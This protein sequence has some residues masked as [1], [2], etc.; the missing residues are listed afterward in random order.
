[1]TWLAPFAF[2]GLAAIAV[3]ILVHLFG[4]PRARLVRFPTLRFIELTRDAPRRRAVPTDWLLLAVRVAVIGIA[5]AALAKPTWPG[6]GAP[7]AERGLVRV[8]LVD[9]SASLQRLTATGDSGVIVA[10]TEAQRLASESG[11]VL[12]VETAWP[13]L[14]MAGASAWL[15]DRS[16][17]RE[18]VI[19]S[20]F[21]PG[22]I[23]PDDSLR[24]ETGIGIRLVGVGPMATDSSDGGARAI[25]I[26]ESIRSEWTVA[27]VPGPSDVSITA[28]EAD[29]AAATA[30]MHAVQGR[31]ATPGRRVRI[32]LP[33]A[34]EHAATVT[35]LRAPSQPWQGDFLVRLARDA[36]V[37][38][39]AS[40]A[41]GNAAVP[42]GAVPL[43]TDPASAAAFG[44]TLDDSTMVILPADGADPVTWAILAEAAGRAL[45]PVAQLSER[46]IARL[47][48]ETLRAM[49]HAPATSAPETGTET[50]SRWLWGAVLAL[51]ALEWWLR[52]RPSAAV[53]S[54]AP[55]EVNERAA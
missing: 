23:V 32:V 5:V 6:L 39:L 48:D 55:G 29:R 2:L 33:G 21:Q 7:A 3:P 54:V 26:G 37:A 35:G 30:V 41:P 22:V 18:V 27:S 17:E 15:R 36:G 14:E 4:R 16:G 10:R 47:P 12:V 19:V 46:D 20:D 9:T 50:A 52:R 43:G 49:E 28:G 51:L 40:P 53:M 45:A 38:S 44:G 34:P 1:M 8:I 11:E 13:S 42:A 24:L 31:A 25:R